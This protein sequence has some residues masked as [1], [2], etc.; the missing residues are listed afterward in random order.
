[1]FELYKSIQFKPEQF[2]EYL[3][4]EE[5]GFS[6]CQELGVPAAKSKGFHK[7]I[8]FY[9][10]GH[11]FRIRT[12]HIGVHERIDPDKKK[13]EQ[14]Q[15]EGGRSDRRSEEAARRGKT[16]WQCQRTSD[17]GLTLIDFWLIIIYDIPNYSLHCLIVCDHGGYFE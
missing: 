10:Y 2:K 15:R 12:A 16:K 5:V 11:E 4:S 3:L 1:M 14:G 8:G 7:Q 17:A 13:A 6:E 9:R